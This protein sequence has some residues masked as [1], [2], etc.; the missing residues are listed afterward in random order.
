MERPRVATVAG[1]RQP[2]AI[3]RGRQRG[4]VAPFRRVL[5]RRETPW[6]LRTGGR[7]FRV[8]GGVTRVVS[9]V[10]ACLG[11]ARRVAGA[12]FPELDRGCLLVLVRQQLQRGVENRIGHLSG[13]AP[14][15]ASPFAPLAAVPVERRR[16][17]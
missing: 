4:A 14:G 5:V 10:V 9:R 16:D 12:G 11:V 13:F 2:V 7:T 15:P 1:P 8:R 6:L 17:G 3:D